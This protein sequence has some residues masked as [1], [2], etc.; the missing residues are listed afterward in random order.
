MTCREIDR[1]LPCWLSGEIAARTRLSIELHLA[2]CGDCAR[3]SKSYRA[4]V[5]LSKLA[6][7]EPGGPYRGVEEEPGE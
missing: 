2:G 5:A 6:F 3:S 4:V 7:E 1:L